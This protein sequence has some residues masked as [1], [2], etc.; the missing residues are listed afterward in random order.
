VNEI[1]DTLAEGIEVPA[2]HAECGL[3]VRGGGELR[4]HSC[5]KR[6]CHAAV[7]VHYRGYW[8]YI[9]DSDWESRKTFEFLV[10]LYHFEIRAGGAA[11]LPVLTLSVSK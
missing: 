9:D 7:A 11:N 10:E 1:I 3:G 4:V 8:F 5:T 2:E 6:P